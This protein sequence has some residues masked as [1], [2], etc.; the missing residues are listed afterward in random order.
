MGK[1]SRGSLGLVKSGVPAAM[2]V[3]TDFQP[4]LGLLSA[5]WSGFRWA[6]SSPDHTLHIAL[7]YIKSELR[8]DICLIEVM[9]IIEQ[10]MWDTI[11]SPSHPDGKY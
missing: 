4:G 10:M 1:H 8:R 7:S 11:L 9:G 3:P 5:E 2:L 6:D